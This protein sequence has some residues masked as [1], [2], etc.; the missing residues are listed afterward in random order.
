MPPPEQLTEGV[1]VVYDAKVRIVTTKI[2]GVPTGF[3]PTWDG[4]LQGGKPVI[5]Y[6]PMADTAAY[7]GTI[8]IQFATMA[9][10]PFH[11]GESDA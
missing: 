3:L 2:H 7:G 8:P 10:N 4:T 11:P 5:T 6:V 1:F 9:S